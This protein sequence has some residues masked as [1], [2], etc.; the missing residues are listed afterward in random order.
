VALGVLDAGAFGNEPRLRGPRELLRDVRICRAAGVEHF[1][2]F[3]LGGLLRRGRAEAWLESF[4]AAAE[5]TYI[6]P[7]NRGDLLVRAANVIGKRWA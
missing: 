1:S 6:P 2:L 4:S 7:T 5:N 3:D